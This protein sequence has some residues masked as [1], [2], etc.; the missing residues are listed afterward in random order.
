M[1]RLA[2]RLPLP[3]ILFLLLLLLHHLLPLAR[4]SAY[5]QQ[6]GAY[7]FPTAPFDAN[8]DGSIDRAEAGNAAHFASPGRRAEVTT[9]TELRDAMKNPYVNEIWIA[10]DIA[11]ASGE[12][13]P[14]IRELRTLHVFGKC[15]P[16]GEDATF[17]GGDGECALDAA[18]ASGIFDVY[19]PARLVMRGVKLVNGNAKHGGALAV[20]FGSAEL[21]RVRFENNAAERGGGISN[22]HGEVELRDVTMKDNIASVDGSHVYHWGGHMKVYGDSTIN[23]KPFSCVR[24]TGAVAWNDDAGPGHVFP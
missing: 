2:A 7:R 15:S 21:S 22:W 23:G 13:L 24:A 10:A 3:P 6:G 12:A 9:E 14:P 11:L 19:G 20:W 4:V 16:T 8:A 17:H 1:P 18:G 5:V